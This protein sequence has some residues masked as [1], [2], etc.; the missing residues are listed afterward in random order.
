MILA[1]TTHTAAV[2]LFEAGSEIGS[3]PFEPDF[4]DSAVI[5]LAHCVALPD[6]I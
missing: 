2:R 5:R 3:R 4:S 1:A 6:R